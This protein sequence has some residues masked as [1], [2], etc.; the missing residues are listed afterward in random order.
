M[1]TEKLESP[2]P[3]KKQIRYGQKKTRINLDRVKP[4]W[5]GPNRV[6]LEPN[7]TEPDE[8]I[9]TES[10]LLPTELGHIWTEP[11]RVGSCFSRT[12]IDELT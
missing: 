6:K 11:N 8:P 9:R 7:W 12:K 10:D 5:T 3:D 4:G 2:E 1:N